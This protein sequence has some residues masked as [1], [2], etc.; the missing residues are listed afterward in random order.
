MINQRAPWRG[1]GHR[2][3]ARK[4]VVLHVYPVNDLIVHT[5]GWQPTCICGPNEEHAEPGIVIEH[6]SLDGREH[7]P[8]E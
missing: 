3:R 5:L 6:H 8:N 2:Q 4:P 1:H 7:T